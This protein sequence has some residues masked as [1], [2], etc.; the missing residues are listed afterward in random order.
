MCLTILQEQAQ[1]S[2][3]SL[4]SLWQQHCRLQ[5]FAWMLTTRGVQECLSHINSDQA[6]LKLCSTAQ[7]HIKRKYYMDTQSLKCA[8][9]RH[10]I[11]SQWC[12][13]VHVLWSWL[14]HL[15]LMRTQVYIAARFMDNTKKSHKLIATHNLAKQ[16]WSSALA[17]SMPPR[18][19]RLACYTRVLLSSLSSETYSQTIA[20]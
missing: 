1:L 6:K 4:V 17:T 20:M 7:E 10:L 19:A 9:V 8:F 18:L 14:A 5:Y 13:I 2:E 11:P 3:N 15:I 12:S 16:P